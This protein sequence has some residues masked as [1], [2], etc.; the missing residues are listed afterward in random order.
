M[1]ATR[2][3][4]ARASAVLVAVLVLDQITKA[5]VRAD[6]AIGSTRDL[7]PGV[8]DLVHVRNRGVAFSALSDQAGL[9]IAVI[10]VA[11]IGLLVYFARNATKPLVWLPVGMLAGGALGNVIDRIARGSVTDFVK[12]PSWPA[13]NVADVAITVGVLALVLVVELA[14]RKEG[15]P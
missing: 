10:V 14:A 8:V 13:F 12:L 2:G 4:W 15:K 7:L 5:L 9:V 6:V 11:I 3:A 1:T